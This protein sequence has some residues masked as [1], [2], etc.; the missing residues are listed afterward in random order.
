MF[1]SY[2]GEYA[3]R[4]G[5]RVHMQRF[6][7]G[8]ADVEDFMSSLAEG[9]GRPDVV[10]A[11][12]SFLEQ[13]G[14]PLVTAELDCDGSP[15]LA[16]RQARYLPTGSRGDPDQVW[17]VP[18]CVR[19]GAGESTTKAC[20]LFAEPVAKVDLE[21]EACPDYV[22]PNADG[23]GY[24]RFA[25]SVADWRRL[26]ASFGQLNRKE[27]LATADSLSAGYRA[28]QVTTKAMIDAARTIAASP[29]SQVAVAPAKELAYLRDSLVADEH[30]EA[31]RSLLLDMYGPRLAALDATG[32]VAGDDAVEAALFRTKL[33]EILALE[34]RD[35]VLRGE[36]ARRAADFIRL[37]AEGGGLDA[38]ALDP[39]LV[40][41]ALSVGV[42]D[43]GATFFDA[44]SE[45][46][47]ASAD[48]SFRDDAA[49]ALGA[50]DDAVIGE[51]ARALLF[52]ERLR[53]R[54]PTTL[55]FGLARRPSQRRATFDWFVANQ[56][57]FTARISTFAHRFLPRLA[58]GFCTTAERDEVQEFFA[59][60][61][62][63]LHGIDRALGEAVEAIELCVA[64]RDAKRAET[65]EYFS[66]R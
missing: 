45:R 38:A 1:E 51:R 16:L 13:P 9:S 26:M 54:E 25:L 40:R 33:V 17:Q 46:L 47:F 52:D 24:Y 34:A 4:D 44:L 14:V 64:L 23:A 2:L 7:Y 18:M 61:A 60:L 41:I 21:V 50:T 49:A 6:A 32:P 12:R 3:F 5:L 59:P 53:G 30:R 66:A 56:P 63:E 19:L 36:L 43:T 15:S 22:M 42:Q 8:V 65:D 35:P 31:V 57:A 10:P 48:A 55:L 58:N 62:A 27:A 28:N 29:Y 39:A 20:T 37:G 11:F